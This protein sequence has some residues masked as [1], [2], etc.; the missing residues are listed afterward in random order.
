MNSKQQSES[1]TDLLPSQRNK[2]KQWWILLF[3]LLN[4]GTA[5]FIIILVNSQ[6]TKKYIGRATVYKVSADVLYLNITLGLFYSTV[7]SGKLNLVKNISL[8]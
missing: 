1:Q 5:I 3:N 7:F 2:L 8:S 6:T 4:A